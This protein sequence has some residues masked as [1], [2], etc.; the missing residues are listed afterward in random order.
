M[1]AQP[2]PQEIPEQLVHRAPRDLLGPK[3]HRVRLDLQDLK[4]HRAQLEILVPLVLVD[5]LGTPVVRD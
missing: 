4:G 5:K 1:L 3:E 2:G